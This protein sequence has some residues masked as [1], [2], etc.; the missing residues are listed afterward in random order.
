MLEYTID[1]TQLL[2][3]TGRVIEHDTLLP[4]Q[5]ARVEAGR[6]D[7]ITHLDDG[8]ISRVIA[9][10]YYSAETDSNGEFQFTDIDYFQYYL[11]AKHPDF[12]PESMD[13]LPGNTDCEIRL[14]RGF[15]IFGE[16]H[17]DSDCPTASAR[18]YLKNIDGV[19]FGP[20]SADSNGYYSTDPLSPGWIFVT[21]RPFRRF[22]GDPTVFTEEK[23]WIEIVDGDVEANFGP[24][25]D[26]V[27]WRGT[28]FGWDG[29]P[30]RRG[31]L[32]IWNGRRE[33]SLYFKR[34]TES[35]IARRAKCDDMGRFELRKLLPGTYKIDLLTINDHRYGHED[36][37][38]E[39]SFTEPGIHDID[40]HM[41]QT[42]LS[43]VVLDGNR[44]K[45]VR[46]D[47]IRVSAYSLQEKRSYSRTSDSYG[48]F[49]LRG[50]PP[51][52][53]ILSAKGM[54]Y[55]SA[56]Y[57][58][59]TLEDNQVIKDIKIVLPASGIL[60][61]TVRGLEVAE[62]MEIGMTVLDK[63]R[64]LYS[65]IGPGE[66]TRNGKWKVEL[67]F[68]IGSWIL[69]LEEKGLGKVEK[70]IFINKNSTTHIII[71]ASEFSKE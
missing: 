55:A 18:I 17:D 26:H 50:I 64:N 66:L 47:G 68:N 69:V 71:E 5:G 57:G 15:R 60:Q 29:K 22:K 41:R 51:D 8:G 40:I 67:R 39:I 23:R 14:R 20:F 6:V 4:V 45:P 27:T 30:V 53:Y 34:E 32:R 31:G 42:E 61:V 12:A 13:V 63:E 19:E 65:T 3:I 70:P 58:E 52:T 36:S 38:D 11:T 21:A 28:F 59:V 43:G 48:R 25:P 33:V 37:I 2:N 46:G 49:C 9:N 62:N 56:R 1:L 16:I 35:T 7:Y 24:S 10:A 54:N 44:M